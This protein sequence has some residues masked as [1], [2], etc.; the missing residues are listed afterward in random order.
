MPE[1]DTVFGLCAA[2]GIGVSGEMENKL[3][4]ATAFCSPEFMKLSEIV[5]IACPQMGIQRGTFGK[6]I[7]QAESRGLVEHKRHGST[8]LIRLTEKGALG[9][10]HPTG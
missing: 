6:L 3:M 10:V 8:K 5:R 9:I 2:T 4:Q 1:N 7:I